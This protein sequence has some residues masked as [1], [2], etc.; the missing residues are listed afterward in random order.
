VKE[1]SATNRTARSKTKGKLTN[2]VSFIEDVKASYQKY[3]LE[4]A[5]SDRVDISLNEWW[6]AFL[7]EQKKEFPL[8][9]RNLD[10]KES[11]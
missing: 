9:A 4:G 11:L 8:A 3:C 1:K 6:E 5:F 7:V 2:M 10:S